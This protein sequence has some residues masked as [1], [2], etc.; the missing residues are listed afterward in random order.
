MRIISSNIYIKKYINTVFKLFPF[1]LVIFG[2]QYPPQII[3]SFVNGGTNVLLFNLL[4]FFF[5]LIIPVFLIALGCIYLSFFKTNIDSE[6]HSLIWILSFFIGAGLLTI[7][8]FVL[9]LLKLLYSWITISFFIIVLYYFLSSSHSK[10]LYIDIKGWVCA[11]KYK[12]I[13]KILAIL[14]RFTIIISSILIVVS[15]GILI[16]LFKDGGLHQYFGYF[17]ETRLNHSTWMDPS[18]P[19]L[20]DYLMGHGQGVYLFITSFTNEY[21]IQLVGVIFLIS[22]GV[23]SRQFISVLITNSIDNK[24]RTSIIR[25]IPDI[26]F[27][28]VVTSPILQMETARFHLETGAFLLF[29]AFTSSLVILYK[30]ENNNFLF[31]SQIPIL[32]GFPLLSPVF[33]GFVYFNSFVL[34]VL[35]IIQK[36]RDAILLF[37]KST[38]IASTS[39]AI[40]LLLN[41]LYVGIPEVQPYLLF[42]RF[43]IPERLQYW[44]S[45]E[46]MYYLNSSQ[47]NMVS[48]TKFSFEKVFNSILCLFS[49]PFKFVTHIYNFNNIFEYLFSAIFILIIFL[50]FF[51][52]H[53][54]R[55]RQNQIPQFSTRI[56]YYWLSFESCYLIKIVIESIVQ[57]SSLD[58][59]LL[60][61]DI[62]PIITF[63]STIILFGR[64]I[65]NNKLVEQFISKYF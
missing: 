35:L 2:L 62:F 48:T 29:L 3:D 16:E 39:S 43:I 1:L 9:G 37:I 25:I 36:R 31:Y 32:I 61:M 54:I 13:T 14:L 40:S 57:Q 41:W 8:G 19:I 21:M 20:Y 17:A 18:H 44:S 59:M 12:D 58:R 60:F 42:K 22:I 28:L 52:Q 65:F 63:F 11:Y 4:E 50:I 38:I 51:V 33:V 49:Y 10:T 5:V 47:N 64:I 30:K 53:K 55:N 15:K 6:N 23:L 26:V 56:I 46:L 45:E 34:V 7:I 27:L 24:E